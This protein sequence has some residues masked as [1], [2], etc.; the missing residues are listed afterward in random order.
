M[1]DQEGDF[2]ASQD[3]PLTSVP[4]QP[5]DHIHKLLPGRILNQALAEL[6]VDHAVD[7]VSPSLIRDAHRDSH[8]FEG[9]TAEIHLHRVSG[10]Q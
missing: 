9:R 4:D 1:T 5:L 7:H 3:N 10:A 6:V 2:G 8:R